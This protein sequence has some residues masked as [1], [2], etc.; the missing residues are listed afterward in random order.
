MCASWPVPQPVEQTEYRRAL[1][2]LLALYDR[3]SGE[4]AEVLRT[5]GWTV[6]DIQRLEEIR[7]LVRSN[8]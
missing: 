3:V 6:A 7:K 1:A 4:A 8:P 5:G 2:D